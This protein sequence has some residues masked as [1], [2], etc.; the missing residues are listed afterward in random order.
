MR[1]WLPFLVLLCA[2]H[3]CL[4][5]QVHRL[6]NSVPMQQIAARSYDQ[7]A[8]DAQNADQALT[9]KTAQYR[10]KLSAIEIR[11]LWKLHGSDSI[12][13]ASLP[14]ASYSQLAFQMASLEITA[15]TNNYVSRL[16]LA[17]LLSVVA[18]QATIDASS[19]TTASPTTGDQPIKLTC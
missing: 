12:C 3:L 10:N 1:P 17:V 6:V 13:S 9:P 4:F 2:T 11:I 14:P 16:E 5:A 18:I 19:A 8:S 15:S 7:A